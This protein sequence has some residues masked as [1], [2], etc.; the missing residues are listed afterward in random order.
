MDR[1]SHLLPKILKKRGLH[2]V[3]MASVVVLRAQ[4]WINANLPTHSNT[5]KP[6]TFAEG[7]LLI[8]AG[9]AIALSEMSR[10]TDGLLVELRTVIEGTEIVAVR[11]V[12]GK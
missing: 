3:A 11:C 4:E 9:N 7:T 8:E 2:Q 12:R 6:R 10:K 5:L 1:L